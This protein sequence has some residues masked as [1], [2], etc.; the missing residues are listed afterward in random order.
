MGEITES[1]NIMDWILFFVSAGIM[2]LLL[3]FA[4]EWFWVVMPFTFTYLA[5]ALKVI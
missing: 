2:T 1:G 3:I 5:K 4:N